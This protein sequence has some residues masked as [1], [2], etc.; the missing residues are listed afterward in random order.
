MT[1][2]AKAEEIHAKYRTLSVPS[3]GQLDELVG[4]HETLLDAAA[5]NHHLGWRPAGGENLKYHYPI[6]RERLRHF[7][8]FAY[9]GLGFEIRN[10]FLATAATPK[11]PAPKV[12]KT[13]AAELEARKQILHW[14]DIESRIARHRFEAY[15]V[16]WAALLHE[17]ADI[18]GIYHTLASASPPIRVSN[19]TVRVSWR[20]PTLAAWLGRAPDSV[21]EIGGGHGKFVRDCALMMPE[22]RLYLTDLPFNLIVQARYLAEYF[23]DAVNLCLLDD[24]V[25]DPEARITVIAPWRLAEI[26]GPVDVVANFLSFQHMDGDNLAWYGAAMERLRA[27][28]L[29][30]INRSSKRDGYDF[31]A[32]EY[33]F[34]GAFEIAQRSESPLGK[35][36]FTD[37]TETEVSAVLELLVRP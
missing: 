13:P 18:G 33:P 34:R 25:V 31:G 5:A 37:G 28:H 17:P 29:F 14:L 32:D 1:R 20:A 4:L 9:G 30:H 10:D 26:P 15:E 35:A 16:E 36:W 21:L 23:G 19:Q 2:L 8:D 24:H 27:G 7:A 12:A 11:D 22:T 3:D 6:D